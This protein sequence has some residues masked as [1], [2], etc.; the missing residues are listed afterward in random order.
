MENRINVFTVV[1]LIYFAGCLGGAPDGTVN[2]SNELFV[3]AK[4]FKFDL[5]TD[6]VKSGIVD[7]TIKN[8]GKISHEFVLLREKD[9]EKR[10]PVI[11]RI[12][13]SELPSGAVKTIQVTLTPDVYEI[14]C[15]IPSH[16]KE[17]M[18][19]ALVVVE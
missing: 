18:K 15:H 12:D 1:L 14:G 5:S 6:T 19:A 11:V 10:S 7:I 3:T 16:Y 2:P 9:V 13:R 4:E 8:E 17:G